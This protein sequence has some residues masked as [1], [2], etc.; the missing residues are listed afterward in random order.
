DRS[1]GRDDPYG[2]RADRV[3]THGYAPVRRYR[4]REHTRTP[5]RRHDQGIYRRTGPDP[6]SRDADSDGGTGGGCTGVFRS[7]TSAPSCGAPPH[8]RQARTARQG[9]KGM[10]PLPP[11]WTLAARAAPPCIAR[12]PR[13]RPSANW[14][15]TGP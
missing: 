3:T 14:S 11:L 10:W 15:T 2:Y 12:R 6:Y 9:H 5:I 1:G 13:N 8:T 4:E 7:E